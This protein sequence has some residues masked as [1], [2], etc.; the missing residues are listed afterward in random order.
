MILLSHNPDYAEQLNT[1]LVDLQLS[2]HT[3]GGQ[4]T[5]FGRWAPLLSSAYG[6]KYRSGVVSTAH[7][8]V[9]VSKGIGTI[10]PPVR[11]FCRPEI[12]LVRLSRGES[13][14]P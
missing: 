10:T 1:D 7:T 2:G 11:L 4:V 9:V 8:V 6:Q 14:P 13:S 3:H 5:L 12:V